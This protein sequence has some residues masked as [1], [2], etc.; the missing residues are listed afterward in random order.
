MKLLLVV[1]G[2]SRNLLKLLSDLD[3]ISAIYEDLS[4]MQMSLFVSVQDAEGYIFT[5][6]G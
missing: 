1:R 6:G 2:K 3:E 4:E 5:N